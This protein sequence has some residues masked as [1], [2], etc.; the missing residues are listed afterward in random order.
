MRNLLVVSCVV[1]LGIGMSACNFKGAT[2][3]EVIVSVNMNDADNSKNSLDWDGTYIGIVPCADCEG[4]FTKITLNKDN[5][6][7]IKTEYIGK[8][9]AGENVE[10]KFEWDTAGSIVTLSG[11]KEKSMPPAYKVGENKLVQLDSD[12]NVVSGDLSSNYIL[13]K[14]DENLVEK[15]WKLIEINGVALSSMNPQPAVEAF[16]FFQIEGNKVNGNSGCNN[17][18]GTYKTQPGKF[19]SFSQMVS[20]RRMCI[21]ITIEDQMDKI[22]PS[23]DSHFIQGK[24]LSL[25]QGEN[26]LAKFELSE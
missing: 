17:F 7:N 8:D 18:V 14:I 9:G 19:I 16:I 6:F 26:A 1:V 3:P 25:K 23:V 24:T 4:I 21:D 2:K 20:T 13:T 5:T 12:G 10:G 11:L 15:K 22:F